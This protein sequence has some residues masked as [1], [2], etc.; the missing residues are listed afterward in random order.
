MQAPAVSI[1]IGAYNAQRY[2]GQTLDTLLAQT[3]GDFELIVVNDGSTDHTADILADYEHKDKR[4]VPISIPHAGIV[5]AANAG[6]R[7]AKAELVARADSDDLYPADRLEKQARYL[8]AHPQCAVVGGRVQMIEPYGSPLKVTDQPTDH[9]SIEARL[10]KGDGSA[11]M[12]TTAMLR[13]SVALQAGFYRDKYPWSED[14]D[15]F[16]R[17]AEL[18]RLANLPDV[19]AKYRI[20]SSST[21]WTKHDIQLRNKP[22]LIREAHERRGR[23]PPTE[24]KFANPWET[25]AA[26][27]YTFWVWCALKDKNVFGAR[28]H[29][30]SALKVSPFSTSTWR[31][32]YCAL[33]GH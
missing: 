9:D 23:T 7:A 3:F 12:Q 17:M 22:A 25:P 21:N 20:H 29:A 33:R 4:I 11:I 6:L 28:R 8:A 32:A 18:G 19:L 13:K 24:S 16:L 10:L 14:L 15:L 26:E 31:A 30:W 1:V 27:R 5:E 2:L